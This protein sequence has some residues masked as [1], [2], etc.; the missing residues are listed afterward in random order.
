MDIF[1]R[2]VEL[3]RAGGANFRVIE[4][5]PVGRSD[6][7]ARVRGTRP[8]QGAKAIVCA[9]PVG[10]ETRHVVAVVPGD[11]RVDLKAVARLVG[12]KKGSFAAPTV[13]EVIT[14]CVIGAI[15]PVVFDGA[16]TLVVD[17]AF[18]DRESEIAFNAGRLD[19]SIVIRAADYKR[20][21]APTLAAIAA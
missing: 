7:V 6:A 18:L 14:G 2:L 4:H 20:I 9:I 10:G 12:G 13:A 17:A 1:E 3:F 16:L 5:E 19:R 15:P 11:R 8:E 21:V